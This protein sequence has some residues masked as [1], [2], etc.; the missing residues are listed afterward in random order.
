MLLG[1]LQRIL[2]MFAKIQTCTFLLC[3]FVGYCSGMNE[4]FTFNDYLN[5]RVQEATQRLVEAQEDEYEAILTLYVFDKTLEFSTEHF[6][7]KVECDI[8]YLADI[9]EAKKDTILKIIADI[10]RD[11]PRK[12][13]PPLKQNLSQE[14]SCEFALLNSEE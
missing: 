11:Q 14:D 8:L 2:F 3:M 10:K 4:E 9:N 12:N 5:I 1:L 13:L 7:Q 6:L